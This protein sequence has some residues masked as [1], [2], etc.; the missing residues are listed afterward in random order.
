MS[1]LLSPK[2]SVV[3]AAAMAAHIIPD[4]RPSDLLTQ[5]GNRQNRPTCQKLPKRLHNHVYERPPQF[6]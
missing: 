3:F 4:Q 5:N 2:S 6:P 1:M